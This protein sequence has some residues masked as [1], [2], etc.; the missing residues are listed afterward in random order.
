[1]KPAAPEE[2]TTGQI[3]PEKIEA[4]APESLIENVDYIIR[5]ALG[6]KLF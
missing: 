3:T 2:K 6:K 1:M 4:P 5:H